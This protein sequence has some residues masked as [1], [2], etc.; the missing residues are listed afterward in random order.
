MPRQVL[1]AKD[2]IEE[3]GELRRNRRER[4]LEI[5]LLDPPDY[6]LSAL[7]RE[8]L[9]GLVEQELRAAC[10]AGPSEH[11]EVE[12]PPD[13]DAAEHEAEQ[14]AEPYQSGSDP[15]PVPCDG[16]V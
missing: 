9:F 13:L 4:R 3:Q 6:P 5:G 7:V 12:R 16:P 2:A 10:R 15:R 11:I 14:H 1:L 8:R